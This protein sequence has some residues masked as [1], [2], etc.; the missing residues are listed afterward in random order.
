MEKSAILNKYSND[1]D[2]L[3]I[4]KILDK[5]K[6][7]KTRNQIVNTDFLDM[8]Q[9][10]ISEEI[11]KIEKV[12]NYIFYKP[13]EE[14][15]RSML[16]IYPEKYREL[17]EENKFNYG[18]IVKAIRIKLPN[19]L[20]GQYSHKNYLSGIMKLGIKR[21]K[22]GD[23]LVFHDGADIVVCN[24]IC[25]YL[26]NSLKQLT[27]FKK[28]EIEEISLKDIRSPEIKKETIKITVPTLRLDSI[29]SELAH[30]SRTSANDIIL[31][32]RV[33]INYENETKISKLVKVGDV[34]VIRGKGKF[35]IK[36]LEGKT[37]K[38][39][40]VLIVEHYI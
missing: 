24:E 9:K 5:I 30:C 13:F 17:F 34:L 2:K 3:F 8:Y 10:K 21:E 31:S 18:T 25:E 6:L 35:I 20:K 37:R 39:K 4:S 7:A 22:I 15:D 28:S 12:E 38:D 16:V 40:L 11:L 23:I 32:Q 29:V 33:F 26:I 27:R 19:E 1:E 36:E 14:T